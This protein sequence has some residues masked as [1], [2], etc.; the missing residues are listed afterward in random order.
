[1]PTPRLPL[2]QQFDIAQHELVG[3][4]FSEVQLAIISNMTY[5]AQMLLLAAKRIIQSESGILQAI[6]NEAYLRGRLEFG[7][8][9]LGIS[10]SDLFDGNSSDIPAESLDQ[11][12]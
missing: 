2:I 10:E 1:M 3:N 4:E 12:L 7:M 6:Q 5:E 8:E 9:I 11:E